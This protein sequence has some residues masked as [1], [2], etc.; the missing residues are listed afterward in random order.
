MEFKTWAAN[1]VHPTQWEG[2]RNTQSNQEFAR[3][4]TIEQLHAGRFARRGLKYDCC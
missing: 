1:V 3:R 2:E 4:N